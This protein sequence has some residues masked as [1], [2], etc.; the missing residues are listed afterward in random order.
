MSVLIKGAKMPKSCAECNFIEYDDEYEY[1]CWCPIIRSNV[2]EYTENKPAICPL[3]EIPSADV[4]PV[5]HGHWTVIDT[6]CMRLD[7]RTDMM[8][9]SECGHQIFRRTGEIVNYCPNCGAKM[10]RREQEHDDNPPM[11][12]FES[13]GR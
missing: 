2:E 9:C 11:E 8:E 4:E 10:I 3:I 1:E 12:Y 13:G 5:R 6:K 7:R